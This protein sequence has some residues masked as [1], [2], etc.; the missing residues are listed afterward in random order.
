MSRLNHHSPTVGSLIKKVI[1]I[2]PELSAQDL[3][4]IIRA[5]VEPQGKEAGEFASA[6][7]V[8]EEKALHLARIR[9]QKK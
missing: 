9:G 6:E 5:C 1:A 4:Q 8:N 2:N 7:V 3:I